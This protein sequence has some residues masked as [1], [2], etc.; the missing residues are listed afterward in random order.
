MSKAGRVRGILGAGCHSTST[1]T[2]MHHYRLEDLERGRFVHYLLKWKET[3][4]K[5]T[6]SFLLYHWNITGSSTPPMPFLNGGPLVSSNGTSTNWYCF[7][8]RTGSARCT[9]N[10]TN[11][12]PFLKDEGVLTKVTIFHLPLA[13][14]SALL[15]PSPLPTSSFGSNL[16]ILKVSGSA[17][18]C[19]LHE[20]D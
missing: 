7:T 2:R 15:N 1:C 12:R 6:L 5:S 11:S 18:I 9:E 8:S 13:T 19:S 14:S 20:A 16:G 17:M 4:S 10:H 3:G